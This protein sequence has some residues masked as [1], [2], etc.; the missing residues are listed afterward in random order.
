LYN[1]LWRNGETFVRY[2]RNTELIKLHHVSDKAI[3]NW[4]DATQQGK[5][6]LELVEA[7]GK[8]YIADSLHNDYLIERLVQ[9]GKKYRNKRSHQDIYPSADFY[10]H[11]NS[12]QII[13]I[14]NN[15]DKYLELP[16]Q[17]RYFGKGA[18]YW[19]AHLHKFYHATTPNMLRSTIELMALERAYF[20]SLLNNYTR[21]NLIDIGVGNGLAAKGLLQYLH[22]SG[23]LGRYIG[24]DCSKDLLDITE[25]NILEWFDGE[26][27]VDKYIKD[28]TVER[29]DEIA[30]NGVS[31][32]TTLNIV[33]FLGGT[34]GNFKEPDQ[35][36]RL[37]RDS[38]SKNDILVTSDELDNENA[39]KF[40]GSANL[41][42]FE[43]VLLRNKVLLDLLSFDDQSYDLE[44]IFNEKI[45]CNLVQARLKVGVTIHFEAGSFKRSVELHKGDVITLFRM[46]EWTSRELIDLYEKSGFSQLRVTKL[47][48]QEFVLVI[49]KVDTQASRLV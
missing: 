22:E 18:I 43:S 28:I 31:M 32:E 37:I 5:L 42:P 39:R 34:G 35:A 23:K 48:N 36:L 14:A 29:F 46:W 27:K 8:A 19:N 17:Y 20:D 12:K 25:R 3:R 1:R 13:D 4:I 7:N 44:R 6:N 47:D 30:L 49:S 33:L 21:V 2:F 9:K 24:I 38:I 40:F 15:L 10:K 45:N 16:S 41:E 11:Y 26:V